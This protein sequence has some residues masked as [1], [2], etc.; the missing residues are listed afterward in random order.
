MHIYAFL[1][2]SEAYIKQ[3][4]YFK[5]YCIEIYVQSKVHVKTTQMVQFDNMHFTTSFHLFVLFP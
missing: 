1:K 5:D 2:L 3:R 4:L